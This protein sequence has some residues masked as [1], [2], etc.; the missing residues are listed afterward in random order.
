MRDI[1]AGIELFNKTDF[2]AAHDFF[3]DCW[4]E[5][6]REDRFFYQGLVQI[7]VGFYHL[8]SGN[9]K[10]SLSQLKKGIKK[11]KIYGDVYRQV[12]L[13]LLIEQVSSVILDL[14]DSQKQIE[15]IKLWNKIPRIETINKFSNYSGGR[16][17]NNDNR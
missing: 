4:L 3:E 7:S 15:L 11:L 10:G 5:C 12:N 17:G 8:I 1:I 6:E 9:V 13:K 16:N 2:F 14:S